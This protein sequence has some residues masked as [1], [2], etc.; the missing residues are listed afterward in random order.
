MLYNW[1]L[2]HNQHQIQIAGKTNIKMIPQV[3]TI[4]LSLYQPIILNIHIIFF[5][6]RF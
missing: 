1:D 3:F 6:G 2:L 4:I 5:M